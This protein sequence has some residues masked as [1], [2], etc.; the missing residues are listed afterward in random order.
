MNVSVFSEVVLLS[1]AVVADA[2][3]FE[4]DR[5]PDAAVRMMRHMGIGLY[6]VMV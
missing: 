4:G 1:M 5:H 2:G 3:V 6:L